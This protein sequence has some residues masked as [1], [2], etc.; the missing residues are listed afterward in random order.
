M[1]R[2]LRLEMSPIGIILFVILILFLF[3]G[4]GVVGGIPYG[5]GYG[6]GGISAVGVL[7]LI[8]VVLLVMRII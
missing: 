7:L 4:F 5:Y 2:S 1:F 6:T 8:L 3:G